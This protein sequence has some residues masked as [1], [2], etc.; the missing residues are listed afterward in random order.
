MARQDPE[1]V[2]AQ[3]L[4]AIELIKTSGVLNPNMT[5]DKVMDLTQKLV[6]Q[7]PALEAAHKDTFITKHFI[8]KH[9]D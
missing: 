2:K 6:A 1:E 7:A 8:Y 9:E 3:D 5:L 4:R